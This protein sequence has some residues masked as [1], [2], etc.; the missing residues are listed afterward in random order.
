M[1]IDIDSYKKELLDSSNTYDKMAAYLAP[2]IP[3]KLYK[4]GSF[5][6]SHWNR[7]IFNGEIYLARASMFN[8]PFDCYLHFDVD[9]VLDSPKVVKAIIDQVNKDRNSNIKVE[10]TNFKNNREAFKQQVIKDMQDVVGVSC[11]SE[12]WDSI[13]MWSHY[14]DSHKGFCIE[15]D[16][17]GLS[18][19][20]RSMLYRVIYQEDMIDVTNEIVEMNPQAGFISMLSK[21]KIWDYEKEWR[22]IRVDCQFPSSYYFRREIKSIILGIK[23]GK[24]D[25]KEICDWAR[26]KGIKVY[27]A[28][29]SSGKFKIVKERLI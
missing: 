5:N 7:L 21:A 1:N 22:M 4:Y 11:F 2:F 3:K 16:T 14:A 12:V 26:D 20:K 23:C 19:L 29:L 25:T 28:N 18:D 24:E 17:E 10:E 13:L 15:Y 27:Q 9:K 6:S 8:D